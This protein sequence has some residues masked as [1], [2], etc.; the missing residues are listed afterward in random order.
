MKTD[1]HPAVGMGHRTRLIHFVGIGGI[2]MSGI[3]EVLLNLGYGVRGSD[4]KASD[5]TR[6]LES[7]GGDV[8]VGHDEG[9][10]D[11]VDVVVVSSAI[12][13]DN[14]EVRAARRLKIP[15]IRRAEMLA[16]L[17]RLKYGIAIGGTHGKTTTTSLVAFD[18]H[19]TR[20]LDP[21]RGGRRQG[22]QVWLQLPSSVRAPIWSP[23]RMSRT[24]PSCT[25]R[26]RSRWSPT[27]IPSTSITIKVGF[28]EIRQ[29]RSRTS[30]TVSLFTGWPSCVMDHPESASYLAARREALHVTYGLSPQADF[31]G[32]ATSASMGGT[33]RP[34]SW[35]WRRRP[36]GGWCTL[37]NA[38]GVT[39]S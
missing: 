16:E 29:T 21:D 10:V 4:M 22:Q 17:M 14:A 6:R 23:R 34:S 39:T 25:C 36:R 24:A 12:K 9:H 7:L 3:A 33:R 27:S 18:P 28:E 15:V 30:S 11:G 31:H 38:R 2:G 19:A 8:R 26:P 5:T 13:N 32:D 20:G 37:S 1:L 35:W